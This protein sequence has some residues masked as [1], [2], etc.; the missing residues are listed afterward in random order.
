[1]LNYFKSKR[2][3]EILELVLASLLLALLLFL[4]FV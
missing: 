4:T 1:M 2:R 3:N